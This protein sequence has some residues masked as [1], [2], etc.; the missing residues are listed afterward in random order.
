MYKTTI[1]LSPPRT[2]LSPCREGKGRTSS[3]SLSTC[4]G[5]RGCTARISVS[6]SRGSSRCTPCS[7]SLPCRGGRGCRPRSCLPAC[8]EGRG[9]TPRS[10]TSPSRAGIAFVFYP[11]F[12]RRNV[13]SSREDRGR[14]FKVM[15]KNERVC[16]CFSP[17]AQR[18]VITQGKLKTDVWRTFLANSTLSVRGKAIA[19]SDDVEPRFVP[20][21]GT[22][23]TMPRSSDRSPGGYSSHRGTPSKKGPPSDRSSEYDSDEDD[24]PTVFGTILRTLMAGGAVVAIAV[25]VRPSNQS[26]TSSVH[27]LLTW[28]KHILAGIVYGIQSGAFAPHG[29]HRTIAKCSRVF[30]TQLFFFI[31]HL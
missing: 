19:L 11:S 27:T 10:F 30:S 18:R 31:E 3:S 21:L 8:R 7:C 4:R 25:L 2:C 23:K 17:H 26:Y 22:T 1:T 13:R 29:G 16:L 12:A 9:C 28:L 5:G 20:A 24:G 14:R 15:G 6:P